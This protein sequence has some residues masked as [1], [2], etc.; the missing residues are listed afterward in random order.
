SAPF[1]FPLEFASSRAA[2]PTAIQAPRPGARARTSGATWPS[3]PRASLISSPR[4]AVC[5]VRTQLRSGTCASSGS[6]LFFRNRVLLGCGLVLEPVSPG[7][8]DD[9]VALLVGQP[10]VGKNAALVFRP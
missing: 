4:G 3:G 1:S 6:L 2:R 7:G 5:L 10:I 8:H 9:L